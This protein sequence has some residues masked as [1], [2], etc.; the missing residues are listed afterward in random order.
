VFDFLKRTS[1]IDCS[2]QALG[3]IGPA[4]VAM[5]KAEEL[6]AHAMSIDLRLKGGRG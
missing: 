4:A 2:G 6:Q 5:A 3:A 1:L